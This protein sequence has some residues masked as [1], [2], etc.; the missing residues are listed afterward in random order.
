MEPERGFADMLHSQT[1]SELRSRVLAG[2]NGRRRGGA[3]QMTPMIDII[4]LLLT[5]FVVTAKFHTPELYLPVELPAQPQAGAVRPAIIEPLRMNIRQ[6]EQG[7][8][9]V[10]G[11]RQVLLSPD[12][13]EEGLASLAELAPLIFERQHRISSDPIEL[14]CDDLVPWDTVVKVYDLLQTIGASN[15]TFVISE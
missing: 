6:S 10:F 9:V 12:R 8:L 7:S 4:F 5:F 3:L 11:D 14:V 2:L 1:K 15:I 13:P